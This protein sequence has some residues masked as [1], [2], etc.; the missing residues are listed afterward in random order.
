VCPLAVGTAAASW[1]VLMSP[2]NPTFALLALAIALGTISLVRWLPPEP[3]GHG[4]YGSIDGLRGYLAFF[5]FLHHST[6]WYAYLRTGTWAIVPSRLYTQLGQSSVSL[7]FMITG[8]LFFSKLLDARRKPLDWTRLYI[9]RVLRLTPLYLA[10]MVVLGLVVAW[11]SGFSLH[12]PPVRLLSQALRWLTFT[13]VGG[14]PLNGVA[15]TSIVVAQVTW[16][17][18][19]EWLFYLSLPLLALLVRIVPP[20]PYLLL[21]ICA[22]GGTLLLRP[23]AVRLWAFAGGFV[24]ALVVRMPRLAAPL[25]GIPA[26]AVACGC[27]VAAVFLF[28]PTDRPN[29][30][31]LPLLAIAFVIIAA[32]N[33]FAGV[34]RARASRRLGEVSYSL[35]L[36]HGIVLFVA[37]RFVIGFERARS[38]PP[39]GH[40]AVVLGCTPVLVILCCLSYE[41]VE[42]PPLQWAPAVSDRL[43]AHLQ[44]RRAVK[45]AT[46][47]RRAS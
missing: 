15:E 31:T 33:D 23:E 42:L 1:H 40:W 22:L 8:F 7:F 13:I 32:G 36:L 30:L 16:S 3:L 27:L 11:L 39:W 35:Y 28:P 45:S 20:A 4:R 12:E 24:A 26:S 17:L 46:L 9:S 44:W 5:V 47:L 43:R 2:F 25:R 19:Y 21:S 34:L 41:Y 10:A 14:P 37:F 29:A 38:L 18:A 6:V